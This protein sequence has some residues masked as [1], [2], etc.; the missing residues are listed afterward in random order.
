MRSTRLIA[1]TE[2]LDACGAV[3]NVDYAGEPLA[4][5]LETILG[6]HLESRGA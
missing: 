6:F 3:A 4:P 1:A 2:S 5:D